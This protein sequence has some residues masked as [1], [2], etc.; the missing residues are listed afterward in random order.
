MVDEELMLDKLCDDLSIELSGFLNTG[1]DTAKIVHSKDKHLAD[2]V[3]LIFERNDQEYHTP[4]IFTK[5][6][7]D[8]IRIYKLDHGHF[9]ID[10]CSKS[11]EID[12]IDTYHASNVKTKSDL[13]HQTQNEGAVCH[14]IDAN[15]DYVF[16]RGSW[17]PLNQLKP[18]MIYQSNFRQVIE[19]YDSEEII[20]RIYNN[21]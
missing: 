10:V 7:Q 1:L 5:S 6:N 9:L 2:Y 14:V 3:L 11:Y 20:N 17:I 15:Q 12:H 16:A 8:M 19:C 21:W 13:Y 4:K 18:K